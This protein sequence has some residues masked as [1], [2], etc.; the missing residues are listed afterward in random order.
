M[1]RERGV[2]IEVTCSFV[3]MGIWRWWYYEEVET[4]V[5]GEDMNTIVDNFLK[6]CTIIL[7]QH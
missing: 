5:S 4:A 7:Q 6:Y 1:E 2:C 3:L